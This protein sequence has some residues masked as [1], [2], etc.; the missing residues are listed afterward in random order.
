MMLKT[1]NEHVLGFLL[2]LLNAPGAAKAQGLP[3][4]CILDK[5]VALSGETIQV[6][7]QSLQLE[8]DTR[9]EWKTSAGQ[10][11][12]TGREVLWNVAQV[13]PGP[14]T[15]TARISTSGQP[16][17]ECSARL[18]IVEAAG[19]RGQLKGSALSKNQPEGGPKHIRYGAYTYLLLPHPPPDGRTKE[20]YVAALSAWR[21]LIYVMQSLQLY[22]RPQ[23]LNITYV[24]TTAEPPDDAAAAWFLD[25]YDYGRAKL[26][27]D[28]FPE[29]TDRGPFLIS[30]THP[31]TSRPRTPGQS[32]VQDLS[33]VPATMVAYWVDNFKKQAAQEQFWLTPVRV[34]FVLRLRT[35]L[36]TAGQV[37][38][39]VAAGFADFQKLIS[40]K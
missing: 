7:V 18:L 20:R 8:A 13:I 34:P 16:V 40:W 23:L 6:R 24:P 35:L 4:V 31:L 22:Y 10:L 25:H 5:P 37:I 2:A 12:G 9:Y 33:L 36:E 26:I 15:I 3:P 32:L 19:T 27:L 30:S 39:P 29:Q 38:G 21:D 28:K 1:R 14:Q 11:R 17:R